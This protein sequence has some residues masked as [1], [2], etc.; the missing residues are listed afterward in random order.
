MY[1]VFVNELPLLLT[2]KLPEK[3]DGKI[4]SLNK[5]SVLKAIDGLI[6]KKI[7]SAIIYD[8]DGESLLKNFS[9]IIPKVVAAGG[10]VKNSKGKYLFIY[11][12]DKWDLPKGKLDKGEGIK[13]AAIREVEEETGVEGLK[14]ECFLAT[15]YHIFKRSGQY[16]LKEV[17]WFD[18]TSDYS[19]KLVPQ[20]NEGI[21]KVKWK[22][23]KKTQKA[24]QNSYV[25]IKSLFEIES[26]SVQNSLSF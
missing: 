26:A 11:R 15:T 23:P 4:Y 18:M 19:N 20:L 13:K 17:H 3:F 16:R 12:N 24:L 21:T 25:T 9:G 1:K 2:D 22:G 6:T 7:S 10:R 14:I 8:S 5:D